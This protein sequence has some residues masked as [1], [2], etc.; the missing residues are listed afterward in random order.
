MYPSRTKPYF[1]LVSL[2][3]LGLFG[4]CDTVGGDDEA[5][6]A[7][8]CP[9]FGFDLTAPLLDTGITLDA[10]SVR[11]GESFSGTVEFINPGTELVYYPFNG[12]VQVAL[13]FAAGTDT[14]V[15]VYTEP[16][17]AAADGLAVP[18]GGSASL[19]LVGGTTPC[20]PDA[21][22][23]LAT[24]TYDIRFAMVTGLSDPVTIRVTE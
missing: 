14:P 23:S 2:L 21:P 24:G 7:G 1:L 11:T 9:V 16:V 12:S 10:G 13:L 18:P 6:S 4:G 17:T 22:T 8:R 19:P 15:A 5:R 3:L 20:G